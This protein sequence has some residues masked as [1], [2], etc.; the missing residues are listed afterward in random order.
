MAKEETR[1]L[2]K[3]F[4]NA[5]VR[6]MSSFN[7]TQFED[8]C[9]VLLR[10]ILND[11][12][13]LH[14]GCNLNGKPVSYAVDIKTEDCKIVGQSGT[15]TDYFS[16]ADFEKPIGDIRG[17]EKNNPLCEV[18]YL[19]SNQRASDAQHTGLT[20]KINA[21]SP[22]FEVKIYD[23]EKIAETIYEN[24]NAPR[25]NEVWQYLT[26]SS[27]FY[28]IFPKRNCIPQ[29]SLHYVQRDKESKAF[30]ALLETQSIV[31]IVGVSGIGKSEFAKQVT[32]DISQNFESLFW[33]NG[34]EYESL[35]SVKLCRFGYEVNLRFVLENYK[36]L[37]I[38]D[39]LN[40][41]VAKLNEDF[42]K[43]NK[44][45]SKCIITSLKQSLSDA[46]TYKLP[47]MED[48]LICKYIDS[49][50]LNISETERKK[51]V[52]LVAGYPL[53]VNMICASAKDDLFSIGE[54]LSDGALQ[55]L[56]DEHNQRLSER[57]VRKIYDKY[58]AELNLLSYIDCQV[59]SSDFLR[60]IVDR[61]RL[62]YLCRY[63]VLQQEDAYTFRIHQVVLDA[64]KCIAHIPDLKELA[65]KLSCYL[66][67][68]NHQKDIPF[69]T[70]FHHNASFI[71]KVYHNA[72]T[73]EEQKK[74]ILYS[75]LQAENTFSD[76]LKYL[77]LIN[78]LTL[79][80]ANSLYD[81][82]LQADKNE[83]ELSATKRE[84]FS[85]KAKNIIVDLESELKK[86]T[87]E[88]IK[89]ELL[90]H[91][92][93]LYVKLREGENAKP[94]FEKALRICPKAYATMLQLAKIAH[95][96]K[97]SDIS[98]AKEYVST[99]LDD[100]IKGH[101]VPLTIVLACYSVF[102]SKKA[103]SDLEDK[104]IESNFEN[105]SNVIMN[106]LLN[107]NNQAVPT[108]GSFAYSFAYIKPEFMRRTFELLQKLPAASSD[109]V[110]IR[111]CANLKAVEYKLEIDK[112]SDKAKTIFKEAEYYFELLNLKEK[113]EGRS[114][115][116][117]R[118]RYQELLMDAEEWKQALEFSANFD[119]KD[120]EFYYQNVAKIYQNLQDY[121]LAIENIDKAIAKVSDTDY[122]SSFLWN[123]AC[124]LYDMGDKKSLKILQEAIDMRKEDK[125]KD[126]WKEML[127][128]WTMNF[129]P[130]ADVN[131]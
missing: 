127:N 119:D 128:K 112:K 61:I 90:H 93:K 88:N 116:Y 91:I 101:D 125:A 58:A 70:L 65:D 5:I 6:D 8:F 107:F 44:H 98:K 75:R 84:E 64:I 111:A 48:E 77:S 25:C 103:Y 63:S 14:K 110:Y 126:E 71:D 66:D 29:S 10:L 39:N 41:N 79:Q 69:F 105:F 59:I 17:T 81:C 89:F 104:Y 51:L 18:L 115:D 94:Y 60:V 97:P 102:L 4:K 33:I 22:S 35:D 12:D 117:M 86:T 109:N 21:E 19:F 32:K 38:V 83:I 120:S 27:Q 92:G 118:K 7:G 46:L 106:S 130:K 11:D 34:N 96:S 67:N 122:K 87:D 3:Q 47:C 113:E 124:I 43:A 80:P 9:Q 78:E 24:V 15:D 74:V 129:K 2:A 31:E 53:A 55:K 73:T 99:I 20:T 56:E 26:E 131:I 37:V 30:Q 40:E 52:T 85:E 108:L 42:Q 13:I 72:D 45:E 23:V 16:K 76:S 50:G 54:L 49:F 1:M 100:N 82:L 36:S 123:K 121:P 62:K 95:N 114:K 28:D 57:I 68:K